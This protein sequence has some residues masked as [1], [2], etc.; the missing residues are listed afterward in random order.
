MK[1]LHPHTMGISPLYLMDGLRPHLQVVLAWV[2]NAELSGEQWTLTGLGRHAGM[3]GGTVRKVLDELAEKGI[4]FRSGGKLAPYSVNVDFIPSRE[5]PAAK[6]KVK[7]AAPIPTWVFD[8]KQIWKDALGG[9]LWPSQVKTVLAPLIKEH[10]KE[11]V[12]VA[13]KKYA[14]ETDPQWNPNLFKFATNPSEWIRPE[15]KKVRHGTNMRD[16]LEGE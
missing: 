15:S 11:V 1:P 3:G 2:Y 6:Q 13:L 5:P 12:L 8:A 14:T 10:G 16:L 9:V 7:D 4:V